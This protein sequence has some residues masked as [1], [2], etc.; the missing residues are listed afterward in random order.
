MQPYAPSG[1]TD[2]DPCP[3]VAIT[4]SNT[5]ALVPDL[6]CTKI[7]VSEFPASILTNDDNVLCI[8][9]D[10]EFFA[11]TAGLNPFR[12]V[13]RLYFGRLSLAKLMKYLN[14][15]CILISLDVL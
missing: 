12:P 7:N 15:T 6:H 14:R 5:V 4:S 10:N 9:S 8:Q 1:I 11:E 2:S 13:P 3:F